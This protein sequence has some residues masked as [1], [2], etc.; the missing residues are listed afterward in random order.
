MNMPASRDPSAIPPSS[1]ARRRFVQGLALAGAA[2]TGLL[3]TPALAMTSPLLAGRDF[4][5][6]I[7]PTILDITGR[8]RPAVAVNG[9]VPAPL[10]RWRE[11]TPSPCASA[12]ALPMRQARSTGTA[13]CCRPTWTA[14]PA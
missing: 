2:G 9:S 12:T 14:C 10:L 13:S 4:D 1:P 8:P 6:S 7:G 11:A 3:R 5:L